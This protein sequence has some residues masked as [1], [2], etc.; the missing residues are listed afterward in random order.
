MDVAEQKRAQRSDRPA[1]V[2]R[3]LVVDDDPD[4]GL[5]AETV[6][7]GEGIA[8]LSATTGEEA[9]NRVAEAAPDVVL[10]DVVLPGMDGLEVLRLLRDRGLVAPVLLITSH[11]SM[12][13]AME[14]MQSGAYDFLT[15]PIRPSALVNAVRHAA[16]SARAGRGGVEEAGAEGTESA[17]AGSGPAGPPR[18]IGKCPAMVEVFKT[19][20]RV[21]GTRAT[22]LVTGETGTGKELVARVI[23]D[24][25][26]RPGPFQAVNCAAIPETLLESELFGH[27]KGAFTGADGPKPGKFEL[28]DGGTLFLDEIGD[29]PTG[30]QQKILRA[31]EQ[32]EIER[33]G[34]T[35][36]TPVDVR[37]VAA[38]HAPLEDRV[39]AGD[40]RKDLFFRLA[41][42]RISLPPLRDR[43]EDLGRLTDHFVDRL[44]AETRR[45][46]ERVD[47]HVYERLASY[48]WPG[49]VRELR[50]VLERALILGR[51]PALTAADLPE[52]RP[53]D[54][55]TEAG[56]GLPDLARRGASLEEVEGR[57]VRAVLDRNGWNRTESARVLGIHR[58]TLRR[59]IE[60]Y[61]LEEPGAEG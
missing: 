37:V 20:G 6:L 22:V 18:L 1:P 32:R 54:A 7:G 26:G 12:D 51:G 13:V 19:M 28:A 49:N 46:V 61:G 34:G 9:L 16:R 50:N 29:M 33:L 40:F 36:P 30:L 25:S 11:A 27:E 56:D 4:V 10:L 35:E 38:T 43:G 15:K 41:V 44:G 39:A 23:H 60:E 52:L 53:P 55:A 2:E 24:R 17:P 45:R 5:F 57:Y 31:L 59:K 48:R 3:V 58:N 47:D 42:I 21:A 8:V 14:A